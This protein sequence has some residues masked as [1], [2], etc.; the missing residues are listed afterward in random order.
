MTY[1]EQLLDPR[2]QRRRLQIL[3]RDKWCCQNC[4]DDKSTLHVH[5]MVYD[6]GMA[7]EA[8]G[9]ALV[10]VCQSC[11]NVLHGNNKN[12]KIDLFIQLWFHIWLKE[13]F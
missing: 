2:W 11:H 10:T 1:K 6:S 3:E 7:W 13:Q 12:K 5:H 4:M 8:N 9:L